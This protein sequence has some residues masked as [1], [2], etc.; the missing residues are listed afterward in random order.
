MATNAKPAMTIMQAR[1]YVASLAEKEGERSFALEVRAG[2]W[3]HRNDI[4]SAYLKGPFPPRR[5]TA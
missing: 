3:D 2:C 1:E 5:L 4:Q